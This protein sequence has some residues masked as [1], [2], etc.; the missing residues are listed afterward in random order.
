MNICSNYT[1]LNSFKGNAV[2]LKSTGFFLYTSNY[3]MVSLSAS[4]DYRGA[5]Q[6][7]IVTFIFVSTHALANYYIITRKIFVLDNSAWR[8]TKEN[9]QI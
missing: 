2:N 6:Y 9:F 1:N 5:L 4:L 7:C 8:Q 3:L